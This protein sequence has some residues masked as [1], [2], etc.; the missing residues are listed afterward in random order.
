[1][2]APCQV[3]FQDIVDA[4]PPVDGVLRGQVFKLEVRI[5]HFGSIGSRPAGRQYTKKV[6]RLSPFAQLREFF[7]NTYNSSENRVFRAAIGQN[8]IMVFSIGIVSLSQAFEYKRNILS[9]LG[10]LKTQAS[11]IRAQ[12]NALYPRN[13]DVGERVS[14]CLYYHSDVRVKLGAFSSLL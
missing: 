11:R 2:H 12:K 8:R 3:G 7:A 5:Q 14:L 10:G 13:N 1:M 9:A 4:Q 6:R